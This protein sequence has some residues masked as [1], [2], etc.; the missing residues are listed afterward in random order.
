MKGL[1][2]NN[3]YTIEQITKVLVG[4]MALALLFIV[5]V[6]FN[7]EQMPNAVQFTD[8]SLLSTIG[9][10]SSVSLEMLKNDAM[11]KWSKFELTTPITKGDVITARYITY[12][13]FTLIAIVFLTLGFVIPMCFGQAFDLHWYTYYFTLLLCFNLL[14]PAI[15]HPLIVK[16]GVDKGILIFM[17]STMLS[18]VFFFA[19]QFIFADF[20]ASIQNPDAVYRVTISVI[21]I[22]SFGLSYVISKKMYVNQDL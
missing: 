8:I 10:F 14:S 18:L 15:S 12:S 19:P 11:S 13:L 7:R 9:A 4:M 2:R 1:I 3:F 5:F 21:C 6:N 17:L 16:F 20:W 22:V